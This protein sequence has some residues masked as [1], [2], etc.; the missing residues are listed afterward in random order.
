MAGTVYSIIEF[1]A[2][3]RAS[4]LTILPRRH[5]IRVMR[6]TPTRAIHGLL[7]AA[8]L[9]VG[10]PAQAQD[11]GCTT[12]RPRVDAI[13]IAGNDEISDGDLRQRIFTERAGRL[14]R[15]FGW[16]VG[17]SACLDS[18]EVGKDAL[19][20][21]RVYESRGYPGTTATATFERTGAR[22][23]HVR[24]RVREARPV[25]VDS[26]AITGLPRGI[27]DQRRVRASIQGE[28]FDTAMIRIKMDSVQDLL[29]AAGHARAGPPRM[30]PV[31]DTAARRAQVTLAYDPRA[32]VHAGRIEVVL[33]ATQADDPV[34]PERDVRALLAIDSGD[35]LRT[36]AIAESQQALFGNGVYRTVAIDTIP[37]A[38]VGDTIPLR[39][40]LV[41]GR[42]HS[43]R[44][45]VGWAT[46]DCFR[47]TSRYTYQNFLGRAH[48]L[49]LDGRLAKLGVGAPLDGFDALCSA[50][51]RRDPFSAEL[52]Y[53]AGVNMQMR[54]VIGAKLHPELTVFS[55]RRTEFESYA[56]IVDIGV[57]ATMDRPLIPRV[58]TLYTYRFDKGQ[59]VSDRA[60]ACEV[61]GL[62]R[63]NDQVLLTSPSTT[64][65]AGVTFSRSA[66]A[67]GSTVVNDS[68]WAVESRLGTVDVRLAAQRVNFNRTQLEYAIYRPL[69]RLLIGAARVQAGI[70]VTRRDLEP[71]VPP[72][73]RFYSGG[74]NTV[75]GF[76][77]N[78]L[79]P[80]VYI[81]REP[82]DFVVRDGATVGEADPRD[83][84]QR[85]APA[86]GTA[87]ALLNL[88]LR[89]REG[90]PTDLLRWVAFVDAGRVWN[91][92]GNYS[93]GELRVTPGVGVRLV[94]PIGPFRVDVGYNPYGYEAGPAFYLQRRDVENDIP[95][96]AICVSPGTTEPFA[97]PPATPV[98]CPASFIPRR[99]GSFLSRLAF[100]FSIGEAF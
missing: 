51:V 68:R 67:L 18:I 75:R 42:H 82:D 91:N 32:L 92:T 60:V 17:P 72:Q 93:V 80:A 9:G 95:G 45:G 23:A 35:V 55:E 54:G 50:G 6:P 39:V 73:E 87:N 20:I 88:E 77:Q 96:R 34:L 84:F 99:S 4:L 48:R 58:N 74:Q 66:P 8:L 94:T 71:L 57:L 62:C 27:V 3:P 52:N 63:F 13:R 28:P 11:R 53:Y 59:T 31:V 61:F 86:G 21:M 7:I 16:D 30:E 69:S 43:M 97:S 81:V 1:T 37:G 70:V 56:R 29:R 85:L 90:W 98:G 79:G 14:R 15:W 49:Q 65:A 26:V 22:T 2:G 40:R 89:T 47:T 36:S 78:Q 33:G 24:I 76:G 12:A 10:S 5:L 46:L 38:S 19:R 44:H 64:H 100:H 41:E 25:L 83:G